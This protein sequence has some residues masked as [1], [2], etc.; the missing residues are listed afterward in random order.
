SLASEGTFG[1]TGYTGTCVWVDP[2]YNLV[3]IFLSNRVYPSVSNKL[4][5]LRIRPRVQDAIYEAISKST[6]YNVTLGK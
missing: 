4:N 1:H 6:E 3:Y 5:S 2:K